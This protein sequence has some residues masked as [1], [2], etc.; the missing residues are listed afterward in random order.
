MVFEKMRQIRGARVRAVLLLIKWLS[1]DVKIK[2]IENQ[3][4]KDFFSHLFF[5]FCKN[6]KYTETYVLDTRIS[7]IFKRRPLAND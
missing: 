7:F 3:D 2:L 1:L 5:Y 4:E 6:L